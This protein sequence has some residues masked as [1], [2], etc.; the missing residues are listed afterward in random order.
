MMTVTCPACGKKTVW[1]DFQPDEIRCSRCGER[2][3][4][5]REFRRNIEIRERGVLGVRFY[6]PRCRGVIARR[7]FLKCPQ[8][9][10]WVFGPLAFYDKLAV[11]LLIGIAYLAFSAVYLIYF[12]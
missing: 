9:N 11:A 10:Y 2:L 5:H 8:C 12:H 6:C 4:L 7:W 1:D 3:N